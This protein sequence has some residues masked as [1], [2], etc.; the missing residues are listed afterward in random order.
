VVHHV[1]AFNELY[2]P[3]GARPT[4]Q[5]SLLVDNEVADR[6]TIRNFQHCMGLEPGMTVFEDGCGIGEMFCR[7]RLVRVKEKVT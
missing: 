7:E 4:S 6:S 1:N 2:N 5:I 3:F